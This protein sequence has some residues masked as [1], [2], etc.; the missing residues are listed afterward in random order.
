MEFLKLS[1]KKYSAYRIS[2]LPNRLSCMDCPASDS[3]NEVLSSAAAILTTM[4]PNIQSISEQNIEYMRIHTGNARNVGSEEKRESYLPPSPGKEAL[5]Q[6]ARDPM[7]KGMEPEA[8]TPPTYERLDLGDSMVRV[9]TMMAMMREILKQDRIELLRSLNA[10][11][12]TEDGTT[13]REFL[14]LIEGHFLDMRL[15]PERWGKEFLGYLT[16]SAF[17]FGTYLRDTI[18]LRDW[19]LVKAKFLRRF[20]GTKDREQ[21]I[22]EL[23]KIKWNGCPD[24]YIRHFMSVV[25]QGAPWSDDQL[26]RL[27][28]SKLPL[29]L[30]LAITQGGRRRFQNWEEAADE[31][32]LHVRLK[33]AEVAAWEKANQE[34]G[35]PFSYPVRRWI[36]GDRR[37]YMDGNHRTYNGNRGVQGRR[38]EREGLM[39]TC[40][41]CKGKGHPVR[42]CPSRSERTRRPGETCRRCGGLGHYARDCA[43]QPRFREQHETMERPEHNER[44]TQTQGLNDKA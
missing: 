13:M 4:D 19:E 36:E 20:G 9:S 18:D 12:R 37:P 29:E 35:D 34:Y 32:S 23:S 8:P 2:S 22:R 25:E 27:F 38:E 3:E 33:N 31:L 42:V 7:L 28:L 26:V 39:P 30:D 44:R 21:L 5:D 17:T 24:E 1:F 43:T 6:E 15:E 11:K 10:P 40:M 14:T 41:E 16:G